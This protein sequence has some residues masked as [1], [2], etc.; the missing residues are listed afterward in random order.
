MGIA[1]FTA[2]AAGDYTI[3]TETAAA[4]LALAPPAL[5]T[6]TRTFGSL[7][8]FGFGLLLV[9]VAVTWLLVLLIMYLSRPKD[10]P[11]P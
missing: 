7:A 6:V 5:Q 4:E 1:K 2:V 9:G 8:W 3:T 11:A 10:A